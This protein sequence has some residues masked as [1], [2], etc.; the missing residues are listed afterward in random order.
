MLGQV[1][2]RSFRH[3]VCLIAVHRVED[4]K[5]QPFNINLLDAPACAWSR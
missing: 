3:L 1:E 4:C 5:V 2:P